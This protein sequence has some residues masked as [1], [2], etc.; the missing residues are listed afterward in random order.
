MKPGT[1]RSF[2]N[3]VRTAYARPSQPPG[4]SYLR[5]AP[6]L[7]RFNHVVDDHA[8]G[9]TPAA[10]DLPRL[11]EYVAFS[12]RSLGVFEAPAL[13]E[14]KPWSPDRFTHLDDGVQLSGG[15]N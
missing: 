14:A 8:P 3:E 11:V 5:P 7:L 1:T 12:F 2:A 9:T 15:R 10:R 4:I 6:S 13:H